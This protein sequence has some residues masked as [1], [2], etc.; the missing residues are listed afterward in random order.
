MS[1]LSFLT[2]T[3]KEFLKP[4]QV[5][6]PKQVVISVYPQ[7]HFVKGKKE[8]MRRLGVE[9]VRFLKADLL[10]TMY[11]IHPVTY[12]DGQEVRR[13]AIIPPPKKRVL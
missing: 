8:F 11:E 3:D 10:D 5:S 9:I 2:H 13:G 7:M 4:E 6:Q 1:Y 12:D